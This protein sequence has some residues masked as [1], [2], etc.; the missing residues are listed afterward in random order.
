MLSTS[1]WLE[2]ACAGFHTVVCIPFF[3]FVGKCHLLTLH[4]WFS[5]TMSTGIVS[6]LLHNLP[7]NGVGVYWISV[8][9]FALNVF[10]FVL[11]CIMTSLRYTLYPEIFKVMITHPVQSMFIGTFPMGLATIINMICFVCVPAWGDWARYLAWGLW[12]FDAVFSVMT[13]LSLAFIL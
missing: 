9:I 4:R 5:V 1:K 13:A 12:I 11:G 6:A 8:I 3:F 10:L 2:N 7:Y